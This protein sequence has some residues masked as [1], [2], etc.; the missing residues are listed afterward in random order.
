MKY[1]T[2]FEK[3][4]CLFDLI[5]QSW[6]DIVFLGIVLFLVLL[7]GLKKNIW[8]KMFSFYNLGL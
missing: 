5:S 7:L 3:I 8:E 4:F 1:T 2:I 6:I